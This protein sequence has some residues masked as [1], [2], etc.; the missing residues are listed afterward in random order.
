[1]M[2]TAGGTSF[3]KVYGMNGM[4]GMGGMNDEK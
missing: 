1:M 3:R 4:G 2:F